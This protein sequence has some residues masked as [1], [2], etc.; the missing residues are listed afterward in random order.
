MAQQQTVDD[1][2]AALEAGLASG[3][4]SIQYDDFSATYRSVAD[5]Q[6]ALGYFRAKKRAA[7]GGTGGAQVSYGG[8][9]R[10]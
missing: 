7:A 10:G 8:F 9:R 5:I 4:A 6:R 2:I 1:V 3:E